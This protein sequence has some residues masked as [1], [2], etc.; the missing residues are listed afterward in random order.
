M[1]HDLRNL[2]RH[3]CADYVCR[4]ILLSISVGLVF[5]AACGGGE[6]SRA[7]SP[8]ATHAGTYETVVHIPPSE[9]RDIQENGSSFQYEL[10]KDGTLNFARY[11][12][13]FFA[14]VQCVEA[15]G[16]TLLRQPE[17]TAD[18]SYYM[19]IWYPDA[20][21]L[22]EGG[23]KADACR[24]EYFEYVN[25]VW[26]MADS[27]RFDGL[28]ADARADLIRCAREGGLDLGEK[29]SDED[30]HVYRDAFD[31]VYFNC[32]KKIQDRHRIPGWA[33]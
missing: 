18:E 2:M 13:A 8:S 25:R 9:L 29:S 16:L 33:P 4:L 11:E 23:P 27:S 22:A 12:S 26:S 15:A 19:L 32:I 20:Q 1:K 21:A 17:V 30:L 5:L 24:L 3:P 14:M 6:A 10:M 7:A 31:P 28:Y